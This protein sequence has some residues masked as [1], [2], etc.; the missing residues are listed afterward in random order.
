M[1]AQQGR[2]WLASVAFAAA[3]ALVGCELNDNTE[4]SP[5]GG[6]GALEVTPT[7]WS[8]AVGS[9]TPAYFT[10]SGG[11]PPYV[12]ST[13]DTNKTYGSFTVLN[14]ATLYA[15]SA[16]ATNGVDTVYTDGTLDNVAVYTPK[17]V[18][19]SIFLT[20]ADQSGATAQAVIVQQ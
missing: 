18:K 14:D 2:W 17:A 12:W 13:T 8:I 1:M 16:A 4:E 9:L 11:Q 3:L 19:G 15:G 20:V 10:A 5:D 7:Y 6:A